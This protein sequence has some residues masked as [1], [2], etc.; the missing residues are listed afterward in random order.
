LLL[1]EIAR[2][3]DTAWFQKLSNQS[4]AACFLSLGRREAQCAFRSWKAFFAAKM[5]ILKATMVAPRANVA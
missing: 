1:L 3:I 5:R 4:A 2:D